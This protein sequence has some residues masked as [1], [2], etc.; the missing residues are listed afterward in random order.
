MNTKKK[1]KET[2]LAKIAGGLLKGAIKDS[3]MPIAGVAIGAVEGVKQSIKMIKEENL[4]DEVGGQGKPNYVRLAAMLG[5]IAFLLL[6]AFGKIDGE[7]L[8]KI[9]SYLK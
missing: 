6:F 2:K 3:I 8:D 4:S 5:M 7:T 1:F 9:L